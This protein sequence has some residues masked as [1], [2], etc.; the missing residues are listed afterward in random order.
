MKYVLLILFCAVLPG[1]FQAAGLLSA[2]T[3][4]HASVYAVPHSADPIPSDAYRARRNSLLEG[5]RGEIKRQ[6]GFFKKV[7][8]LRQ[9][10]KSLLSRPVPGEEITPADKKAKQSLWVGIIALACAMIP[11]YTIFAAIPLGIVA[12]SM[13][14]QAKRMG[15]D[16]IN[17]KGFGIAALGLVALWLLLTTLF[18]IAF[19]LSW[20]KIF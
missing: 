1:K 19:A 5:R 2:E 13:G 8:M 6:H 11:W 7:A 3:I 9:V 12:I 10:R 14:S 15:S 16:K 4:E 17:G 20:V 18:V